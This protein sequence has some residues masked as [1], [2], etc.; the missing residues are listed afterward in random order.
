ML[1]TKDIVPK[2]KSKAKTKIND[3]IGE[4]V[5]VKIDGRHANHNWNKSDKKGSGTRSLWRKL[6]MD[7][8]GCLFIEY[9]KKKVFVMKAKDLKDGAYNPK[10]DIYLKSYSN[11][12]FDNPKG[13]AK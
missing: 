5:K 2:Q 6:E 10:H 4:R 12:I 8:N 1:T 7:E 13:D 11:L 3:L 9:H